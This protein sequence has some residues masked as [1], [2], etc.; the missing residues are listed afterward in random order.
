[1][2]SE[3]A[4]EE[5]LIHKI[6]R[7]LWHECIQEGAARVDIPRPE[8]DAMLLLDTNKNVLFWSSGVEAAL[9][10]SEE[11]KLEEGGLRLR[12]AKRQRELDALIENCFLRNTA[13]FV[14][15]VGGDKS[16][17]RLLVSTVQTRDKH[18]S[19][20]HG[21]VAIFL[22][23]GSRETCDDAGLISPRFGLTESEE[24]V[25]NLISQGYRPADIANVMALSVHTVRHHI[26]KI[27]RKT[28]VHSQ[29]QLT[30]LVL[31]HSS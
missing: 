11:V 25:A 16:V 31:K 21:L 17:F 19:L 13:G 30:A 8:Y 27:Y 14:S 23:A 15:L 2:E 3:R 29:A 5:K 18:F 12:N 1:M 26:K 22:L 10:H 9:S 4:V 7:A 28:G 24:R 6:E 20:C